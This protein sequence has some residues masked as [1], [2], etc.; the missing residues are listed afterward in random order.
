M[1]LINAT[2]YIGGVERPYNC[3]SF[4]FASDRPLCKVGGHHG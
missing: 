4:S 2:K 3:W 1:K